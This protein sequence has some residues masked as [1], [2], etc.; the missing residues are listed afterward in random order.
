MGS[1]SGNF[2]VEDNIVPADSVAAILS[3]IA[4]IRASETQLGLDS[5]AEQNLKQALDGLQREI[6]NRKP[7]SWRVREFLAS[8]RNITEGAAGSLIA[9]GILYELSKLMPQ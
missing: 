3:L 5:S 1:G 2:T 4:Q 6:E 8:I 9:S 7:A